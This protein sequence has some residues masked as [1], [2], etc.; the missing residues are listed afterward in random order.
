VRFVGW[1]LTK[2]GKVEAPERRIVVR[3]SLPIDVARTIWADL[4]DALREQGG[5]GDRRPEVLT[6]HFRDKR[7]GN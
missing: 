1:T 3:L 2:T 4:A 5:Y 7:A 6:A